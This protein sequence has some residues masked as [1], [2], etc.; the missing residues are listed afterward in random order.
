[1]SGEKVKC[2]PHNKR[3]LRARISGVP[4]KDQLLS[5]RWASARRKSASRYTDFLLSISDRSRKLL[6]GKAAAHCSLPDCRGVLILSAQAGNDPDAIVGEEA[7]IWASSTNGPRGD[8]DGAPEDRDDYSNLILLCRNCHRKVDTHIQEY[9]TQRLLQIKKS[10]ELW[11]GQEL[12][13]SVQE[14]APVAH[15]LEF[16]DSCEGFEASQAWAMSSHSFVV[17]TLGHQ[18]Q[19][20]AARWQA[21][22]VIIKSINLQRG[23]KTHLFM[24]EADPTVEY[25]MSRDGFHVVQ[26]AYDPDAQKALP[27]VER[28]FAES[29]GRIVERIEVSERHHELHSLESLLQVLDSERQDVTFDEIEYAIFRL[30]EVAKTS[31]ELVMDAAQERRSAWW[32]DGA[33]A[34]SLSELVREVNIILNAQRKSV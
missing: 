4:V 30:R 32:C 10:H 8:E 19:I 23:V 21:T 18:I 22:G 12:R 25:W 27:F 14:F 16:S 7:H 28:I 3:I 33:V 6:W 15:P 11:V 31:P 24:S 34:Q 26:Y 17:C 1:M 29:G 9:S 20:G 5:G 2:V 13:A